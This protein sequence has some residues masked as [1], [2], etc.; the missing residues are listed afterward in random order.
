MPIV[1]AENPSDVSCRGLESVMRVIRWIGR[2][3]MMRAAVIANGNWIDE[4]F[5]LELNNILDLIAYGEG[6]MSPN[7]AELFR[8]AQY[9]HRSFSEGENVEIVVL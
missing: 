8:E 6:S 1:I 3:E 2:I 7:S 9:W 4:I 5:D